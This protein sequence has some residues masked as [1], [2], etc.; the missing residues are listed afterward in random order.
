MYCSKG[1]LNERTLFSGA[2]VKQ[3]APIGSA[4]EEM[5][6]AFQADVKQGSEL[7]KNV[8]PE[9][10]VLE[11]AGMDPVIKGPSGETLLWQDFYGN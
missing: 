1:L 2:Y 4:Q 8:A 11:N 10:V 3:L 6:C 5:M 9:N 7:V